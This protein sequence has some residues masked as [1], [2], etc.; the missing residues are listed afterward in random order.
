MHRLAAS[1]DRDDAVNADDDVALENTQVP[2]V[3]C[4]GLANASRTVVASFRAGTLRAQPTGV[5][6]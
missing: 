5:D 3:R 6:K 2:V 4:L 1:D